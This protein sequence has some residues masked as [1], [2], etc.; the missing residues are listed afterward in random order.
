MLLG[1]E[2]PVQ[3]FVP[4]LIALGFRVTS[5]G[6]VIVRLNV[7]SGRMVRISPVEAEK[8]ARVIRELALSTAVV[9]LKVAAAV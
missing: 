2:T 6:V 3:M 9:G 8:P 1:I 4:L 7:A 5:E